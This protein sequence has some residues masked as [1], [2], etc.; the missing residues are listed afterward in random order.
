MRVVAARFAEPRQA[1]A[2]REVLCRELN[3][4]VVEIAPLAHPG[5][6]VKGDAL[7]AG[8]FPDDIAPRAVRLVVR[9]GGEIVA[10]IDERW[11]GLTS[12]PAVE[13]TI[14]ASR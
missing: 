4:L 1:S 10:N 2:A 7:L 13:S 12:K 14:S 6:A 9:L 8:R 3:P 11:T 5:E